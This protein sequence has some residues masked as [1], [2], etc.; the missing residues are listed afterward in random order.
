MPA[1]DP[2]DTGRRV[3]IAR[4]G[5]LAGLGALSACAGPSNTVPAPAGSEPLNIRAPRVGDRWRYA[6]LNLYNAN[7]LGELRAEVVGVSPRIRVRV[8]QGD[9]RSLEE[10]YSEAWVVA[11]DA[12]YGAPLTFETPVPVI[13]QAARTGVSIETGS[14]YRMPGWPTALRWS[15]RLKVVGWERVQ[16]PAGSFEALRVDRYI[17]L[18]HPDPFKFNP[19]RTDTAWFSPEVGRWV[20]REWKGEWSDGGPN[21][22]KGRS[23]EGWERYELLDYS[24]VA[25]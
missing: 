21:E 1:H 10:L 14:F 19:L 22:Q 5:A 8:D 6:R 20:A 4:L 11:V 17:A 18:A 23:R 25:G 9:G 13:P 2:T 15:Q 24:L 7:R 3:A 12:L 16:V